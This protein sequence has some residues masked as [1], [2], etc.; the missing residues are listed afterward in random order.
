MNVNNITIVIPT[1][2]GLPLLK[3]YLPQVIKH[4]GKEV[5]I[6]IVD[7][8]SSDGTRDYLISKYPGTVLCLRNEQNLFFPIAVNQGFK[9]AKTDF[10]VLINNDVC[11]LEGYLEPAI[12]HLTDK[13]VFAVTFDEIS[14][15][16]PLVTWR[17]KLQYLR[18]LDK[19][20][21]RLSAWASGGSAI[22]RK[23][24][25]DELGGLDEIY[26]PGYWEDID[27]GWR[28]WKA[29]YQIIWEP[30]AKVVHRH[31]SSF[32]LI[33]RDYLNLIKQRNE[34]IFNWKN[35][36]DPRLRREH[37][38]YLVCQILLHPGYL[39]VILSALGSIKK[40]QPASKV[41]RS[42][43]EILSLINQPVS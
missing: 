36:S 33:N 38:F 17:G 29:G 16:W 40:A 1:F 15:S 7:N 34:L 41:I 24:V 18:G 39:K 35:I 30:K 9:A 23:S 3:K 42:D 11:P 31:E 13:N 4:S 5:K 22:F 6:I 25:W 32:S 37:V 21:P 8:G 28:A 19:S 27:I 2:N 20:L 10:I 26:S 14:S 12:R 43:K